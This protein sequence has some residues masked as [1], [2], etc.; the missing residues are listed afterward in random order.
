MKVKDMIGKAV[1]QG[2][3][4]TSRKGPKVLVPDKMGRQT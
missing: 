3:N 4:Y 2:N 1:V